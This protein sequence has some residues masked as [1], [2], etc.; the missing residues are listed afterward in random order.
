MKLQEHVWK[1][2]NCRQNI[3]VICGLLKRKPY[4]GNEYYYELPGITT[5]YMTCEQVELLKNQE[6]IKE[7]IE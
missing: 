2:L 5:K 6:I 7:I 3:C 1:L 4:Y